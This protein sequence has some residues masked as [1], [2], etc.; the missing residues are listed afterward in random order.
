M[1]VYYTGCLALGVLLGVTYAAYENQMNQQNKTIQ[2]DF[3]D[4]E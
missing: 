4:L 1:Y 3:H 2:V